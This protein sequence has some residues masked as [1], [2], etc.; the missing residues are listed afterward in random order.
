MRT[1][2]P[3]TTRAGRGRRPCGVLKAPR[4]R[5]P[6]ASALRPPPPR[7]ALEGW[8]AERDA[9]RLS[10]LSASLLAD[11]ALTAASFHR[12][13]L[14]WAGLAG[15]C[16]LLDALAG[17]GLLSQVPVVFIDTLHLFPETLAFLEDCEK[18][19]G[20]K[21]L[22]YTPA[23]CATKAEWNKMHSSDL[24]LTD[25]EAY[26]TLAKVEPLQRALI[27]TKCVLQEKKGTPK[28]FHLLEGA[29]RPAAHN[30]YVQSRLMGADLLRTTSCCICT[31]TSD[32][33]FYSLSLRCD[34]WINGRRRDQGAERA[35]LP[36]FEPSPGTRGTDDAAAKLAPPA[37][38]RARTK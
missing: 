5:P 2:L 13:V 22:R 10:F 34:A 27:E 25:G 16:V 7:E 17:A 26:D 12:P 19:Y 20:F 1:V 33:L 15:D 35:G 37:K 23:G 38:A 9:A 11:L 31:V 30:V 24:F 29:R 36:V 8:N 14:T 18:H 6:C 28:P 3:C 32:C 21:A 4:S